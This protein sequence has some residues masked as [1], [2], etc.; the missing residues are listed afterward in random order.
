MRGRCAEIVVFYTLEQK[1]QRADASLLLRSGWLAEAL[2]PFQLEILKSCTLITL[3]AAEAVYQPG[4]ETGG[5]IGVAHG[6]LEMHVKGHGVG[7][8]LSLIAGPG[9]W[10]GDLAALTGRPRRIGLIAREP[11]KVVRLPRSD[12]MRIAKAAPET[13]QYFAQL[14]ARN[15]ATAID[16]VDALKRED[17][18][19]RV[20]KVLLN[21]LAAMP[22][23]PDRIEVSQAD[24][25]AIAGLSRSSVHKAL[26]DLEKRGWIERSYASVHIKDWPALA[27]FM[28]GIS[29]PSL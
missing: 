21:L 28:L 24:L 16:M 5:L 3:G 10:T 26:T 23:F 15:L 22:N 29:A 1:I 27:D 20:G 11:T 18:A 25:G 12:M 9:F 4:D 17:P 2:E 8:S 19:E 13:W 6:S 14:L 7:H